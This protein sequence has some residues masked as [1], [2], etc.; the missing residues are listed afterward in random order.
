M[1]ESSVKVEK[2][3]L[4]RQQKKYKIY[5]PNQ[6]TDRDKQILKKRKITTYFGFAL[7]VHINKN[8]NI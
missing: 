5:Y 2:Q 1:K 3:I 8:V 4:M 6:R 7:P